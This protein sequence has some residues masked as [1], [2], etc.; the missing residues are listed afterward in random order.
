MLNYCV[1]GFRGKLGSPKSMSM[2]H[3]K[4]RVN[5]IFSTY[6]RNKSQAGR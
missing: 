1:V 3:A 5:Q 4:R 6:R 2:P